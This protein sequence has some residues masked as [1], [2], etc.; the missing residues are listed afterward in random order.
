MLPSLINYGQQIISGLWNMFFSSPG[1]GAAAIVAIKTD[2]NH[3]V[4]VI[5]VL[6]MSLFILAILAYLCGIIANTFVRIV[7]PIS[8]P[9]TPFPANIVAFLS[10]GLLA[11][12]FYPVIV[13]FC[14]LAYL[15]VP[16]T[17]HICGYKNEAAPLFQAI[18]GRNQ[19]AIGN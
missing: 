11:Y 17:L 13:F 9:N 16:A 2:T 10:L 4:H 1:S 14:R 5:G 7:T 12:I 3:L 18:A 6:F 15:L 8:A 19:R